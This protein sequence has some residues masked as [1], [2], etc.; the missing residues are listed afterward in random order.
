M[1]DCNCSEAGT[2]TT[3]FKRRRGGDT[4]EKNTRRKVGK[5]IIFVLAIILV[6]LLS[7]V[8]TIAYLSDKDGEEVHKFTLGEGVDIE[9]IQD[10]AEP[11][12]FYPEKEYPEKHASVQIP[13]TAMEWEYV[14]V[15][16]QFFKEVET[17]V[18]NQ[19]ALK[20][21]EISYSEFSNDYGKITSYDKAAS[22][23]NPAEETETLKLETRKG[24]VEYVDTTTTA[25][26]KSR[27]SEN[28]TI[29]LYYGVNEDGDTDNTLAK[30]KHGSELMIFDSIKINADCDQK[31]SVGLPNGSQIQL[32]NQDDT[33]YVIRI[34]GNDQLKG[35]R[36][37]VTAYA[38]QGNIEAEEAEK[39]LISLIE[40]N[41]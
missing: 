21:K 17:T 35:F 13:D 8:S 26:I 1:T 37:I 34:I 32:Y 33:P 30:V 36:I 10:T 24:W 28:G 6:S 25:A 9:L 23:M 14:G 2:V 7:I 31:Y 3:D 4:L 15:K 12:V 29:Y 41:Q 20:F 19:Q 39:A 27:D 11:D 18:R 16:V 38:V 22:V 5:L 40:Q